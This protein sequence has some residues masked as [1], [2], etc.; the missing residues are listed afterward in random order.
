MLTFREDIHEYRLSG[1]VLPSITQVLQITGIVDFSK[2]PPMILAASQ[3][4]GTACHK[5]T[6]LYDLGTL[7]FATLDEALRPYLDNWIYFKEKYGF[8]PLIIEK[9]MASRIYRFAGTPDRLGEIDGKQVIVEIKT[10]YELSKAT[11]LQT[12]AQGILWKENGGTNKYRRLAVLL[13]GDK[14][15]EVKE[16]TDKADEGKF[17]A[18][19]TVAN[20]KKEFYGK[21]D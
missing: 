11:A 18:C 5:A 3:Q 21:R 20:L 13:T 1:V 4:F 19:L 2:V 17:L 14:L 15:P 9:P 12:A 7:D 10:S 8:K 6:E 16:Y